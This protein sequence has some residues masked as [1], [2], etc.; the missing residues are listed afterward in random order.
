[1]ISLSW[2]RRPYVVATLVAVGVAAW[3]ALAVSVGAQT[4]TPAAQAKP[5][6]S[7]AE[8]WQFAATLYGYLPSI[9]RTLSVPVDVFLL[10]QGQS[11]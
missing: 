7:E 10:S 1:M 11:S 5:C 2:F 8:K 3:L 4:P 6:D 9:G